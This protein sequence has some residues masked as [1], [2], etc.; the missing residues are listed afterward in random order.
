[1]EEC[2]KGQLSGSLLSKISSQPITQTHTLAKRTL[3]ADS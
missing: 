3:P 1:M 2:R